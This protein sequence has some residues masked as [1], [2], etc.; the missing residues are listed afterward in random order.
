M[1]FKT[2]AYLPRCDH[3]T[4]LF[5]ATAPLSE[6][7]LEL[8][9]FLHEVGTATSVLLSK[10]DLLSSRDLAQVQAYHTD[11]LRRRLGRDVRVRP[12]SA[13]AGQETLLSAW[14]DEE[15]TPLGH[16]ARLHA[17][18]AMRR[19]LD[20]LRR[21]AG[22]ALDRQA[23]HLASHP[24]QMAAAV[25]SL[26]EE[27]ASLERMNRELLSLRDQRES[28]LETALHSTHEALGGAGEHTATQIH[29]ALRA[30]FMRPAQHTAE[31][32]AR[33]LMECAA[34]VRE[35]LVAANEAESAS[36]LDID[37]AWI[38]C[39]IPLVDL[40]PIDVDLHPPWWAR[41]SQRLMTRWQ[42]DRLRREY[43]PV[44]DAAV[45][46]YLDVLIRWASEHLVRLRRE[47]DGLSRPLLAEGSPAATAAIGD[48]ALQRDLAWL[49]GE[50]HP[51]AV[52]ADTLNA[53]VAT[54]RTE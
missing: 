27:A 18:E 6:E 1:R 30:A 4:F 31:T 37:T 39:D 45:D 28:I 32:V 36:P 20:V 16:R 5:D 54:T 34:A 35:V 33:R 41:A 25:G 12:I 46:A 14:I 43:D 19:R 52:D 22:N 50:R 26:R 8:L 7:G 17:Q 44:L 51:P 38:G 3:A 40:P 2:F 53:A 15:I 10:A 21:Q 29:V 48:A 11:Q 49:R 42:A 23:S 9:A 47:F 13:M 24:R